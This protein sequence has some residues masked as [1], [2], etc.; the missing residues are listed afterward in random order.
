M[1]NGHPSSRRLAGLGLFVLAVTAAASPLSAAGR[2]PAGNT[3]SR[4]ELRRDE[5]AGTM[6]CLIDGKEAF[7]YHYGKD[8]DLPHYLLRSPSGK[9]M[10]LQQAKAPHKYPHHRAVWFADTVQLAGKRKVSFYNAF[11]SGG[12]KKN[13][14]PPFRDRIRHVGF[15]KDRLERDSATVGI[16]LLWEMDHKTPVLDETRA[17]RIDA[18]AGGEYLLDIT[19]TVTAAHGDVAFVSDAVHYAWPYVRMTPQFSVDSGGTITN[20][21]GGVNQAGTHDKVATWMDYTNTIGGTTEG[22]AV[23]SHADNAHPHK[24]LTRDYGTFGP[25]R[26]A[27]KSGKKFVLKKGKSMQ[28]RVG[29]LV[30]NGDVKG[31]K[32]ARRYEQYTSG[33]PGNGPARGMEPGNGAAVR[34]TVEAGKYDRIDTPVSAPLGDLA[35][36]IADGEFRLVEVAGPKRLAVAWQLAPG[37][38]ASVCWILA[39]RTP[40]GATRVY[41]LVAGEPVTATGVAVRKDE[42]MLEISCGKTRAL[43]Y[44]HAPVPPPKGVDPLYTRSGFIHPI[45]SP[46]GAELTQIHPKDHYHHLGLWNPWT[47]TKFEGRHVDFWNLKKGEGTVRFVKFASAEGGPVF[48][49]FRAVQEHVDLSAPGGEKVALNEELDVRVWRA[50]EGGWLCDYVSTQ[51]CA[52]ESPLTL[53]K[54]RYGGFGFRATARWNKNNSNYLTSEGKTRKDGHATRSRWCN[55]FGKTD[56]GPAGVLFLSHPENRAHPEPMR[57]WPQG[58]V[59]FNYCPIQKAPWTLEPGNDYVLRYRMLVYD[60]TMTA[61]DAERVW[62]DFAEPPK[63]TIEGK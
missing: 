10:T 41:E 35:A 8:V 7:V 15:A 14:K 61:K 17:M 3:A 31:G 51:R 24:W 53:N 16:K 9:M 4:I 27:A 26:I 20:S 42:K 52:S 43:R 23:F 30:H 2:G 54:Y 57:I 12:T 37:A 11:Y 29:I 62:R 1:K 34:I 28:R 47:S 36:A 40:A 5:Q 44:R 63:V 22:L 21:T 48:G 55:I 25:R 46:A 60:G 59:F 32:V 58:D 33:K 19:F 39:G 45:W 50:G 38:P 56:K 13:P 49:G 18:L 6:S